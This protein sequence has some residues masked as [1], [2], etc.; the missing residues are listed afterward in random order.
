MRRPARGRSIYAGVVS[1][2]IP[3]PFEPADE[4]QLI[5]FIQQHAFATFVTAAGADPHVSH[6]PVHIRCSGNTRLLVGHMAKA[7]P[8]WRCLLPEVRTLAIF[9]GPHAYVSP[10]WYTSRRSVPTWNYA[11]VHVTGVIRVRE[12]VA[13]VRQVLN[14]LTARYEAGDGSGWTMDELPEDLRTDLLQS[15]VAF[16][17]PLEGMRGKF[18]LSQNRSVED[19]RGVIGALESSP[20]ERQRS[21]AALM[22]MTMG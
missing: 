11:V 8:H 20:S 15:V 18:K 3:Q 5:D 12:D 9:H 13:S 22:K 1:I 2:Y 6:L 16:E 10:T 14:E 21:L 4:Q 17:M 7:N 19:R